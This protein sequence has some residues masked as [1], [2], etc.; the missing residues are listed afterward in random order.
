[1]GKGGKG[2]KEKGKRKKGGKGKREKGEKVQ[3]GKGEKGKKEEV[4]E[5]GGKK[6]W[7]LWNY[8][9]MDYI[10]PA[11]TCCRSDELSKESNSTPEKGK[12]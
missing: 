3:G 6:L 5:K 2:E 1:M 4:E 11:T 8:G 9:I 12:I 7:N 10:S